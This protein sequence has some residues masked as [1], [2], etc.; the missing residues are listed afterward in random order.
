MRMAVI[1]RTDSKH[2]GGHEKSDLHKLL[3][4]TKTDAAA[5]KNC[6]GVTQN[7]N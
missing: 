5:L 7:T 4:R 6:L 3:T 2:W 1:K